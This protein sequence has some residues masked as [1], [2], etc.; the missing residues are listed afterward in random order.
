MSRRQV[1]LFVVLAIAAIGWSA[2]TLLVQ[3]IRLQ[4]HQL[5]ADMRSGVTPVDPVY[6]AKAIADYV[7]VR[8]LPPCN[9]AI[10]RNLVLLSAYQT[11]WALNVGDIDT[12]DTAL[13][14]TNDTLTSLLSCAPADGK[15]WL[16]LA[17][18]T[19]YREGFT[20]HALVAYKMSARVAPGESWLAQKRLEFALKFRPLF[21][22]PATEISRHDIAVLQIA[23]P[24][25]MKAVLKL[26]ALKT[27]E[28]LAALFQ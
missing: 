6:V 11:D 2:P 4:H 13:D 27:P 25:R 8:G 20:S 15:A 23:H 1:S 26:A 18:I 17:M 10:H 3:S 5:F 7:W 9:L 24:I 19:T 22:A 28:E 16:D 14:Q 21:D 12:A